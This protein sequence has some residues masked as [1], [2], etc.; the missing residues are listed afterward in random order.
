MSFSGEALDRIKEHGEEKP[1][2]TS[3][4]RADP[5]LKGTLGNEMEGG[6]GGTGLGGH[7]SFMCMR[8]RESQEPSLGVEKKKEVV[9][10]QVSPA[11][12]PWNCTVVS[13]L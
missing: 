9:K 6:L 12:H 11:I 3:Q 2:R 5:R 8:G 4:H 1:Q 7:V 10:R 13:S